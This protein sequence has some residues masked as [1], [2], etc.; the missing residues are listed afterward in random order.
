V[1]GLR[2]RG[3]F[4]VDLTWKARKLTSVGL[5]SGTGTQAKVSYGEIQREVTLKKGD[6]VNWNGELK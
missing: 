4:E 2:A 6:S 5:H 1:T 3:G